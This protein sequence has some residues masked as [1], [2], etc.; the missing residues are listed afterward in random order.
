M[1]EQTS[2]PLYKRDLRTMGRYL[3]Q[4]RARGVTIAEIAGGYLVHFFAE[5]RFDH[6]E[7]YAL[8]SED[9]LQ[10]DWVF[11]ATRGA[12]PRAGIFSSLQNLLGVS[13]DQGLAFQRTHPVIP[14][15][16]EQALRSL[17]SRVEAQ[18]GYSLV[19]YETQQAIGVDYVVAPRGDANGRFAQGQLPQRFTETFDVDQMAALIATERERSDRDLHAAAERLRITPSDPRLFSEASKILLDAGDHNEAYQLFQIMLQE[20]PHSIE[21]HYRLAEIDLARGRTR[22]AID[23][24]TKAVRIDPQHA[25]LHDL[26]GIIYQRND[27]PAQA[28]QE[29]L[30]AVSLD[31]QSASYRAHLTAVDTHLHAQEPAMPPTQRLA[32]FAEEAMA[33]P[34]ARSLPAPAT[35]APAAP[36]PV[37]KPL[38]AQVAPTTTG[39]PWVVSL[40]LPDIEREWAHVLAAPDATAP[41]ASASPTG[42][43]VGEQTVPDSADSLQEAEMSLTWDVPVGVNVLRSGEVPDDLIEATIT[44][45]QSALGA[46]ADR[47]QTYRNLGFLYARQGEAAAAAEAFRLAKQE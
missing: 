35:I 8:Q 14:Q 45:L 34:R 22:Q 11:K 31:P 30:Q 21:A 9:L 17:G 38:V 25:P 13:R 46:D 18:A 37:E 42:S 47:A 28:R 15:G 32:I 5:G 43:W 10:A 41:V 33:P 4:R 20:Q 6:P 39:D 1:T 40:P 23:W 27:A 36:P 26:L 16:Y 24:L 12:P 2:A 3:N 19:I 44:Q 7:G 29:F